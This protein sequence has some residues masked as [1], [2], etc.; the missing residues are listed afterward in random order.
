MVMFV[1][2]E[3]RFEHLKNSIF[4]NMVKGGHKK[5]VKKPQTCYDAIGFEAL[6]R[7]YLKNC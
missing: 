5:N 6:V 1:S 4:N 2:I 3:S 7:C